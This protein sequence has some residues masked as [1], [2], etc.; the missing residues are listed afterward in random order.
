MS[1]YLIDRVVGTTRDIPIQAQKFDLE[2]RTRP[3][4]SAHSF[5]GDRSPGSAANLVAF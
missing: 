1:N 2:S 5:Q 3:T 4:D